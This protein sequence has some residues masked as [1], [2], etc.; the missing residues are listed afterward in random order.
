[1]PF[2]NKSENYIQEY[3]SKQMGLDKTISHKCLSAYLS[4]HYTHV[5]F[6]HTV[7][8]YYFKD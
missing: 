5:N 8:H 2:S 3:T 7:G 4:M 6:S 1:M